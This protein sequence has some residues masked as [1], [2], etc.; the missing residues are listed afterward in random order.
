M[1]IIKDGTAADEANVKNGALETVTGGD[2]TQV[3]LYAE[4]VAGSA[5]EVLFT[6]AQTL[7]F[8]TGTPGTSYPVTTGKRLYLQSL[9]ITLVSTAATA[10]TTRIR[11]RVNPA[12]AGAVGSP[13][14]FS[15]RVGWSAATFIANQTQTITIP[16][17]EGLAIPAAAGVALTHIEAAANGTIDVALNGYEI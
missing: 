12:G 3:A 5:S 7:N 10:N 2:R 17:P 9:V 8:V 11:I 6:M 14:I 13:I 16:L 15:I 4:G 1:A